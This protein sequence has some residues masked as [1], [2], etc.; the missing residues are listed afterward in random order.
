MTHTV[1]IPGVGDVDFPDS[2]SDSDVVNAIKTNIL[3]QA[4]KDAALRASQSG[5]NAGMQAGLPG[6]AG[7]LLD[8][9]QASQG[10]SLNWGLPAQ[11]AMAALSDKMSGHNAPFE[12]LYHHYR[13]VL[14][15][16][17]NQ[18]AA[19]HPL[20]ADASYALGNAAL[21]PAMAAAAPEAGVGIAAKIAMGTGVGAGVGAAAGGGAAASQGTS[22]AQGAES[23]AGWGAALGF[24][25]PAVA[26]LR[27][28]V[29]ALARQA[30]INLG[31]GTSGQLAA[32]SAIK[33]DQTTPAEMLAR[34]QQMLAAGQPGMAA[35]VGGQNVIGLGRGAAAV[36]GPARSMIEQQLNARAT[37]GAQFA[38]L[39]ANAEDLAG[40]TPSQVDAAY[41]AARDQELPG[42]EAEFTRNP[43][44]QE[45]FE[46]ARQELLRSNPQVAPDPLY[47]PDGNLVRTPTVRDLDL[48]KK[49]IQ[50]QQ[51]NAMDSS[52]SAQ[53]SMAAET[54]PALQETLTRADALAPEYPV[55]RAL[56]QRQI[57]ANK[58]IDRMQAIRD[59]G[60]R[61]PDMARA[62]M[63]EV[64]DNGVNLVGDFDPSE[65]GDLMGNI[66]GERTMT[67]TRTQTL[68]GSNTA[69]KAAD[70][71]NNMLE[72]G[73]F[74]AD[75]KTGGM[76]G[77]A[78]AA[79]KAV[80]AAGTRRM[81]TELARG[82]YSPRTDFLES[83]DRLYQKRMNTQNFSTV[84]APAYS[85]ISSQDL[86]NSY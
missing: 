57:I 85:A 12:D 19:A 15:G 53:R 83:L 63:P 59:S 26:A 76:L 27:G 56:G 16:Q 66:T 45:E 48:I 3:P 22:V 55:A 21:A 61:F 82:L 2:M 17:A 24:A 37:P 74:I 1:T 67:N 50:F 29:Q 43:A 38:R 69:N 44:Y 64:G 35:D 46:T 49:R 28:P 73:K 71:L 18:D 77:P 36:P 39:S 41:A 81:N 7:Q 25:A 52:S 8:P 68:L 5:I 62:V 75:A 11:A 79:L 54:S 13:G 86:G 6:G 60:Q 47:G 84:G 34:Q 72:A 70:A 78:S 32:L 10:M 14:E 65:I 58:L 20:R 23:G 4:Q 31:G 30:G 9:R 33:A 80:G 42:L 51:G 40:T